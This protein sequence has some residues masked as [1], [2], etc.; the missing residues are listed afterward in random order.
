MKKLLYIICALS[1]FWHL[2]LYARQLT[3]GFGAEFATIR[4]AALN[5]QPGDTILVLK[6]IHQG[7]MLVSELQGTSEKKIYIIGEPDSKVI[8]LGG[9]NSIQF[10]NPKNIEI[11]GLIIE[12]QTSNGMNIDDGG[13]YSTPAENITITNCIFRNIAASGNN[14]LL[15]MSGVDNFTIQ[16]CIFENGAAGGS[17]IDMVGCHSGKIQNNS[18]TNMGSNAIQAKGGTQFIEIYANYFKNCGQRTL[19]LGGSTGLEYFRPVDAKFEA[20]D[21]S[22]LANIFIGSAAPIAYVGCVRVDVINN[23]IINPERW[24]IRILQETVDESRFEKCGNNKFENNIIYYGNISTE[25]NVG[26][27][28]LP[29]TFTFKN[30]LWYNHQNPNNSGPNIP[31]SEI[32][33]KKGFDPMFADLTNEN[34]E[35]KNGSPAISYIDYSGTPLA[36]FNGKLYRNPRSAGAFEFVEIS[37]IYE[38]L[39]NQINI[40]PN[41][42]T[43]FL[44]IDNNN[45]N[46]N[47]Y[48]IQIYDIFGNC[49]MEL[50]NSE[51]LINISELSSGSYYIRIGMITQKFVKIN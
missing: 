20:A 32:N 43:N 25:T 1:L 3:V 45:N 21:L 4:N 37:S 39:D 46:F 42:A 48:K 34:F 11:S 47:N 2:N 22:V 12:Q 50:E 29:E 10:T 27:N 6:G 36:D 24:V 15:K 35:L 38:S 5:A 26:P 23:T 33:Q 8:I 13:D 14:D 40:F 9:N 17:G 18:F 7:G 19:N 31:V 49:V 51:N 44:T 41:P 16:N 28:T 30:N